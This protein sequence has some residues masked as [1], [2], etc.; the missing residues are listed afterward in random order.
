MLKTLRTS[1]EGC[2][3][4]YR[5]DKL[6]GKELP[7]DEE[8][9]ARA[10]LATCAR[11]AERVREAEADAARFGAAAP[12]WEA[13]AG[14]ASA[15]RPRRRARFLSYGLLAAAASVALVVSV[16]LRPGPDGLPDTRTKGG[17][18][19]GF[20][21]KRGNA[22]WAGKPGEALRPGDVV[23]F[24]YSARASSYLAIVSA[25]GAGNV[26]VLYPAGAQAAAAPAGQDVPVPQ[27]TILDGATGAERVVGLFCPSAIDLEAVR[28][29]WQ[30]GRGDPPVP[31]GC[32]ADFIV[33]EKRGP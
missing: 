12:A 8:Q 20:F 30:G 14:T 6:V 1:P 26:Q 11:C 7:P 27:S 21:V 28:R 32:R 17:E 25:D 2:L 18:R 10:H 29:G 23:Q 13:L 3:S 19:L 16:V 15:A 33:W 9:A 4:D 5:R 31:P 24:V 22:T